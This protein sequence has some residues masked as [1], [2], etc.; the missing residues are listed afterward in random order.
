MA[1]FQ[2]ADS[3]AEVAVKTLAIY[4]DSEVEPFFCVC[5]FANEEMTAANVVHASKVALINFD[6]RYVI[7]TCNSVRVFIG[8]S[9]NNAPFETPKLSILKDV[10]LF[11][12]LP[13]RL[14]KNLQ[15]Y[16]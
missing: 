12:R 11:I 13:L 7:V 16:I 14:L 5:V 9:L 10:T 6:S 3:L 4:F 2:A 1:E 8:V 15:C